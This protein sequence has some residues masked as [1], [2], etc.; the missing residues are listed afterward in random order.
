MADPTFWPHP[1]FG[2]LA[3]GS[4]LARIWYPSGQ[5]AEVVA[6]TYGK[7]R[8]ALVD[9]IDHMNYSDGW[10]YTSPELAIAAAQAWTGE[11]DTEP[12]GWFRHPLSGRRRPDGDRAREEVRL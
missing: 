4:V 11:E 3:S 5:I 10:C 9:E 8:L 7:G 2:V 12:Q 1:R 6:M